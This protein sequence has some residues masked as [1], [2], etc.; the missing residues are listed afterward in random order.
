LNAGRATVPHRRTSDAE[1]TIAK[2][3]S[4]TRVNEVNPWSIL[5][6]GLSS[7]AN[8]PRDAMLARYIPCRIDAE[9]ILTIAVSHVCCDSETV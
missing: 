9:G 6:V 2:A 8:T 3:K 1:C 5:G 4:S 7:Y